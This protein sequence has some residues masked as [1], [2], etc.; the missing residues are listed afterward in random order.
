[1]I[2]AQ[3]MLRLR[4]VEEVHRVRERKAFVDRRRVEVLTEARSN[5]LEPRIGRLSLSARRGDRERPRGQRADEIA[6]V[7]R[8]IGHDGIL[9]L[10]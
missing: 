9:V 10:R 5:L 8:R 6:S 7:S 2:V 1:L 4:R 3:G